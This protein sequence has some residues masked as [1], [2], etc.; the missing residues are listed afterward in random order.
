M[1]TKRLL[2]LVL[3]VVMVFSLVPLTANASS[4]V[5]GDHAIVVVPAKAPTY[6]EMGW[7]E[8]E[9]CENCEYST[10]A[11]FLPS[12]GGEPEIDNYEEFVYNLAL[13]EEVAYE[14]ARTNPGVDPVALVIKY[15]RTGVDRYN[16]GS[17][18]IMA[19]YEDADFAKF[20]KDMEAMLNSESTDGSYFKIT[21]LKNLNRF[22]LPNGQKAD[23]GHVFGSMDITYHNKGSMNHADVSGWAGDLVDLLELSDM[24]GV[25]GS[26][27]EMIEK[28]GKDYLGTDHSPNPGMSLEDIQGDLDSVYI[29]DTLY[30]TEYYTGALAEIFMYYYTEE[31]SDAQRADYFLKS[32]LE[33][34][35]T[36]TQ[37][38]NAVYNAYMGNKVVSTLEGTR[39]FKSTDITDLRKAVCYAFADYLC[40]LA[41]DYVA[42][43]ENTYYNV[44]ESSSSVLAPGIVQ[45][46][47]RATSADG[48]QMVYYVATA[49]ITRSDVHVFANYNNADPSKWEMARVLDQANAA[50]A[51]YGDP[52]SPD[53]IK[54]YNVIISTNADG[55]NMSTGEPGGLLIMNGKEWHGISGSGFFGIT[56]DGKAI[57]GTTAE[58]NATYKGQL[59]D[60]VGGFGTRLVKDGKIVVNAVSNYYDNRASR[61]AVGI[62]KTGKVVLMVFDGRQEPYS[63]GASMEEI[64]QVM[65]EAGCVDAINLDGGGSTTMV[66][67]LQGTDSLAV[68]NSPSDGAPR[69][70]STSLLMVST[71]PSSTAFD[72]ANLESEYNY[73]TKGTSIKITPV[74]ISATGNITDLPQGYTWEV[75]DTRWGSITEDGTF[76]GLRNGSVEVYLM[77]DGAVIGSK[78]INIVVPESIYFTKDS[79]DAVYG[80]AITLPIAALYEGKRVAL[81]TADV[82]LSLDNAKAGTFN[83]FEFTA[84][85]NSGIKRAKVTAEWAEGGDVLSGSIVI[86]IYKQGENTFDFDKAT[87]GDRMLAYDRVVTNSSFDGALSYTAIDTNKDMVTSYIFA[88]DMTQIPIPQRLADLV[89]MLPGA[90]MENASAWNFLL[91]L[92]E[93][94]STLTEVTPVLKFDS[95]FDVDYSELNVMNEYFTLIEKSFDEETNTLTLRLRWIDQTKAIDP[96]TAN[97]LCLVT[98]IK[99]TPKDGAY[100]ANN[101]I[102]AVHSGNISYKVYL[103]ASA[104]YSF[105][106]KPENQEVFGLLPFVNPDDASEKGGYFGDVYKEFEDNYVLQNSMKNGWFIEDGGYTYYVEGVRM[107]GGVKEVEG[108]YYYFNDKGVNEG[109]TKYT[110]LFYMDATGTYR[111]AK[112]GVLANGWQSIGKDWYYFDTKTDDAISGKH[113]IGGVNYEFEANGKLKSGVWVNVFVG[114]RYYYGPDYYRTKWQEIDGNWYYFRNGV[115]VTG[116]ALVTALDNTGVRRW[117]DFG[118]NG[119]SQGLITG[120]VNDNGEL[121]WCEDGRTKE[122]GLFCYNGDYYYSHISGKLIT[123]QRYYAWLI[124]ESSELP[125]GHYDFGPDGKML[126]ITEETGISGIVEKDG[127]LYY[128]ENGKPTE[129]GLFKYEGAYYYSRYNGALVVNERYYAYKVDASSELPVGHYEFG[130]D[131]RMLNGIVDK[132]GTLY[133]YE[134]GVGVEKGLFFLDGYHYFAKSNGVLATNEKYYAWKLDSGAKLPSDH[135]YF[136]ENGRL[137]YEG[138]FKIGEELYY[139]ENGKPVEKGL[140]KYEGAYY[141]SRY[142]GSIIVGAKHYASKIDASS[143]LGV[144]HYEFGADGKMLN[145]IVD[146]NGTLYYYEN[147]NPKE[148]FLFKYEGAYYYSRYNGALVV[149]GKYYAYKVDAS[150]DLPVGHYE[151]GADGKMLNGIV[152]KNGTLYYYENGNPKE[153]FL[154]EYEGAY[155]YSRY[156]GALVVNGKYY[157]YKVDPTCNLPVGH[158]EFGAD[159][160]MLQGIVEKDGVLYFYENGNPVEKGLFKYEGNYYYTRYN[161]ALVVDGKYYA[162]KVDENCDLSVGHYEFDADGK[163]LDGIVEKNGAKYYYENGQAVEKGLFMVDGYYYYARYDGKIIT[164][165]TYYVWKG[166]G[167]LFE[168]NYIFNELGQI[169]G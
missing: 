111:F 132:N 32:R 79:I 38:R 11:G 124:H 2:A 3:A 4:C 169:I 113:K 163:M 144:G 152:D 92:A 143:E 135:Y 42:S 55:Y 116:Q 160:K 19:G 167:L 88:M 141:Y 23:I 133:Y 154:F 164:N 60:A 7:N 68:I 153:R 129:K 145:G 33:T 155:Y 28:I 47:Y 52:S 74:G 51:K 165:Q 39:E 90:D 85:E 81:S 134:N 121:Y 125:K 9:L 156:N 37:I 48:K 87:G 157:A 53:Y 127:V 96:A 84:A 158:Y 56:N 168:K 105:A 16:S 77:L 72:H 147:G 25:S 130:A 108:Y 6:T 17:W 109:Q 49:D 18:G 126:G 73:I 31:L 94:I 10:F 63:C 20:V 67:K 26:L 93:R 12:L 59:K 86:N 41:G 99:L 162:Y 149:D 15:I 76:T 70:V 50:Q 54:D 97:P 119:A 89:Y 58:Y 140:F 115:R 82:T 36:R 142:N 137:L 118:E 91:Q 46:A 106:Q 114:Y 29:M 27:D 13:L 104:L 44:F 117:Y 161:G 57:I 128:Y 148:K 159:G 1:K 122:I 62:T 107:A 14:Y 101:R 103:R 112:A 22:I 83:G 136:D 110:G 102:S 98:G 24:Y 5:T 65:F 120:I 123:N 166:N 80:S 75:S 131:G 95:R 150:S 100:D 69:S 45:E 146:K 151:F 138:I 78:T 139:F 66:A 61:T 64:A 35:G 30:N 40:E 34:T 21:G 43:T 8:Y 71:A